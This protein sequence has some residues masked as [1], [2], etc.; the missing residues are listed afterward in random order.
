MVLT[1]QG[2][3]LG[4]TRDSIKWP[5]G[6][7]RQLQPADP[8]FHSDV[9]RRTGC[10]IDKAR[11]HGNERVDPAAFPWTMGQG[12]QAEAPPSLV[13]LTLSASSVASSASHASSSWAPG[14]VPA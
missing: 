3:Q 4:A 8:L 12:M 13:W 6:Q 11:G 9:Q 7:G 14:P 10:S 5:S 2:R 1:G